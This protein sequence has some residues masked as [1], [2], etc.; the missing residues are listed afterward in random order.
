M[1][2]KNNKQKQD[3]RKF[4][5]K[6]P[7]SRKHKIIKQEPETTPLNDS[8]HCMSAEVPEVSQEE[9]FL[10]PADNFDMK[11]KVNYEELDEAI[12]SLMDKLDNGKLAC[13][14]CGKSDN[15]R[16]KGHLKQHI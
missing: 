8:D 9:A 6:A 3:N 2:R 14:V 4:N 5:P 13:K 7:T 15:F 11:S 16:D 12:N 1:D 10:V